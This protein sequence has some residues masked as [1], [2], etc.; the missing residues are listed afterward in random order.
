MS[1]FQS[2]IFSKFN[3][4]F[5][6]AFSGGYNSIFNAEEFQICCDQQKKSIFSS[7]KNSFPSETVGAGFQP[8]FEVTCCDT[9]KTCISNGDQYGTRCRTLE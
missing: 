2:K 9:S 1:L 6:Q 4:V 3:T 8:I 7:K 5:P